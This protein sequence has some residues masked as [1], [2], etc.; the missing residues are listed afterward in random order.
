VDAKLWRKGQRISQALI[1]YLYPEDVGVESYHLKISLGS[2]IG[3][4]YKKVAGNTLKNGFSIGPY[5]ER[6]KEKMMP[7]RL[8]AKERAIAPHEFRKKPVVLRGY[9]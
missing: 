4:K 7:E 6:R 3:P 8:K 9:L 2:R 1:G 5:P